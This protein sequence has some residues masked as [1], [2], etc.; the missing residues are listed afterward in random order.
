MVN[1]EVLG[2]PKVSPSPWLR[3]PPFPYP[4][5]RLDTSISTSEAETATW[6]YSLKFQCVPTPSQP[7]AHAARPSSGAHDQ[8][9]THQADN[10]QAISRRNIITSLILAFS[11][12]PASLLSATHTH[13]PH[14]GCRPVTTLQQGWAS[15]LQGRS[16]SVSLPRHPR[17]YIFQRRSDGCRNSKHGAS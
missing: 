10:T 12:I 11:G 9:D 1:F 7:S 4:P 13:T 17:V 15:G 8:A 3:P 14:A 6:R 5:P 16:P 2:I